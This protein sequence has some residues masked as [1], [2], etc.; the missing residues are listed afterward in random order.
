MMK[1]TKLVFATLLLSS[2]SITL[3]SRS[4]LRPRDPKIPEI[5]ISWDKDAQKHTL[6]SYYFEEYA[7][8]KT[9]D[10]KFFT[11]HL[12]P[13]QPIT[14]RNSTTKK[15]NPAVLKKMAENL[16]KEIDEQKTV[17]TDF[18]VLRLSNFNSKKKSGLLILKFKEHPF[19]LKLFMENPESFSKPFAKGFEPVWFFFLA[20]GV[21]RH[22]TGFTRVRNLELVNAAIAKDATWKEMMSTPRK[23]YWLPEKSNWITLNGKNI[24]GK[25]QISCSF[26]ATYGIIADAIDAERSCSILNKKDRNTMM[27]FCNYV[28]LT[29]D[30]HIDNFMIE[31]GT[32]KTVIVDTEHFPTVVG[33][34]EKVAFDNY[35]SWYLHLTKKCAKSMFGRS[36]QERRMAQ[37]AHSC[38]EI[39]YDQPL[40]VNFS[41]DP[42][43]L[44]L[45]V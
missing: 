29:I 26:P 37:L 27:K 32:N 1:K 13:T 44:H 17:Y 38:M 11:S 23:W 14:Y 36:K 10:K 2:F 42:V 25:N 7:L 35:R 39:N 45:K 24:G 34:K 19:V 16:L 15:V 4:P 43:K 5:T 9:F 6:K 22:M 40:G 8:F 20:G 41:L 30:P 3:F 31:R 21:N 18:N 33:L 28:N 12:V